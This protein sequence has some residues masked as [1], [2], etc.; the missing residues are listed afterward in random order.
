VASEPV[1]KQHPRFGYFY[2]DPPD[3][4]FL[5]EHYQRKYF[6]QHQSYSSEYSPA[7][8]EFFLRAARQKIA[9]V[10]A[11]IRQGTL[12]SMRCLEVGAGEGWAMAALGACGASVLGIDYSRE[13]I[14][15]W[16]PALADSLVVGHPEQELRK[17]ATAGRRFDLVWLDNVLEHVPD[18]E[19]LLGEIRDV[20]AAG[21]ML[22]VEVPNDISPLH[23]F[24]QA[25]ALIDR[26][27]WEAYPEHLSYFTRETLQALMEAHGF[28]VEDVIADFPIDLFLLNSAANYVNDR[29]R[30]RDAHLARVRFDEFTSGFDDGET[31]AFYRAL[32]RFSLGRN[33]SVLCRDTRDLP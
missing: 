31:I 12:A 23:R 29:T 30:G 6:Q 7:E 14:E 32:A 19:R 28:R 22:L 21:A 11:G 33:I 9:M 3:E 5:R 4:D 18:P 15:R 8:C 20:M 27:F 1:L 26:P 17:L 13:P 24:L 10:K 16:N 25:R 2:Y